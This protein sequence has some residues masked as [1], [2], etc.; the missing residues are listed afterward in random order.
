M[1]VK[2]YYYKILNYLKKARYHK[3]Y[4]ANILIQEIQKLCECKFIKAT[5]TLNT[6]FGKCKP[7]SKVRHMLQV[8]E[9]VIACFH[10]RPTD[11]GPM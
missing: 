11:R 10:L 8:K 7:K 4:Y 5:L 3:L 6:A 2:S 1:H 9:N